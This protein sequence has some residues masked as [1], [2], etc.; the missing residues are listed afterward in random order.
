MKRDIEGKFALK[1]EKHRLVRSLRLTDATWEALGI[2]AQSL[3]ITRAD[4]LE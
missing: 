3:D 4:L 2:A 1:N